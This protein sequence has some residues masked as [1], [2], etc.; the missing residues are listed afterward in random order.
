MPVQVD[1]P[2]FPG[3]TKGRD[4]HFSGVLWNT[5][6]QYKPNLII[7]VLKSERVGEGELATRQT[8]CSA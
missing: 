2:G 5:V 6:E 3:D 1:M 8:G 7:I 4:S